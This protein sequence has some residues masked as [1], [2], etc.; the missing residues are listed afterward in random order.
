MSIFWVSHCFIINFL[1]K[2]W[3][4]T[5]SVVLFC[6][7]FPGGYA[8]YFFP[9]SFAVSFVCCVGLTG[10]EPFWHLLLQPGTDAIRGDELPWE[11]FLSNLGTASVLLPL[12]VALCVPPSLLTHTALELLPHRIWSLISGSFLDLNPWLWKGYRD[13]WK[14][15]S[16]ITRLFRQLEA[17]GCEIPLHQTVLIVSATCIVLFYPSAKGGR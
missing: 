3:M 13:L 15:V 11:T 4:E 5:I 14:R 17:D 7:L 10:K 2:Y 6:S 12:L 9:P 16:V 8:M 1:Q